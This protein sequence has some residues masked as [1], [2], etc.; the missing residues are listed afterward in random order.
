MS[1]NTLIIMGIRPMGAFPFDALANIIG[2]A[3]SIAIDAMISG[4]VSILYI[5]Q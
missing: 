2:V 1:L 3:A 5:Q 4:K